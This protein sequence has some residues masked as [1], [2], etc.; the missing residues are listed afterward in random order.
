MFEEDVNEK[1]KY[2]RDPIQL[3]NINVEDATVAKAYIITYS[4][5]IS[6]LITEQT[7]IIVLCLSFD[8]S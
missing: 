5:Y 1:K 6:Y 2:D 4:M 8:G 3:C 7:V